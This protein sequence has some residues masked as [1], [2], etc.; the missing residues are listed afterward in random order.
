MGSRRA[1][2]VAARGSFDGAAQQ[3]SEVPGGRGSLHEAARQG[4]GAAPVDAR[5]ADHRRAGRERVRIVR[6]RRGLHAQRARHDRRERSGRGAV[7]HGR[8]P[9]SAAGGHAAGSAGGRELR[10]GRRG[11]RVRGAARLQAR[12]TAD[13]RRV[14][15]GVVRSVGRTA[16]AHQRRS[17]GARDR[18]DAGAGRIVQP[19]HVPRRH[20]V[21][22]HERRQHGSDRTSRRR[23]ATTTTRRSTSPAGRSRSISRSA[24]R[25]SGTSRI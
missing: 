1:A 6:Q 25:S 22:V 13:E 9:G 8:R 19:L 24:T 4:A 18:L 3:R 2:R 14:L 5:R 12:R 17:A 15:G 16:R 20:D 11:A 21:R 23:R 7:V 10:A